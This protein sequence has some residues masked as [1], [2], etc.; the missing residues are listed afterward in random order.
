MSPIAGQT[1]GSLVQRAFQIFP[2]LA[3]ALA[4]A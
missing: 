4:N 3:F 2:L 1:V